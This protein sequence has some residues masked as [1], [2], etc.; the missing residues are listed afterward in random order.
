MLGGLQ[1]LIT[2]TGSV[3]S[4]PKP[5]LIKAQND[6]RISKSIFSTPLNTKAELLSA[7]ANSLGTRQITD[8]AHRKLNRVNRV[9][10]LLGTNTKIEYDNDGK[11]IKV[12]TIEDNLNLKAISDKNILE[13]EKAQ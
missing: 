12:K 9:K 13:I 5:A 7:P 2:N 6:P 3:L 10:E 4:A 8:E 1:L 11:T